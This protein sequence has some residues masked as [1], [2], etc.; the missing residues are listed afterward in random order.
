MIP[1]NPP[2]PENPPRETVVAR[3]RANAAA[4]PEAPALVCGDTRLTWGAFD[5]RINRVANAL[6]GMGIRKGDNV[7]ILSANSIPYAELFMGILRAGGC[8]TPLSSMAA[9][10]A[11]H[12]M[13]ADC[14]ARAIFVAEQYFG[15]VEGFVDDLDLHRVAIDFDREGMADYETLLAE[16]DT[17]DPMVPLEMSDAF[18]LIYSSGT[19]GTP[20]GILHNHWMRAAQMDRVSPNGYDDNARTLISTPLYSN[21]TIVAFIPTLFG[22]STVHLMPKFD[23]RAYLE[24]VEREGIT[25]TMLVPVQYK[26]IMDVPDFDSFDLSSMRVKFSTSAPLRADVK[27]DVLDRFPGKLIEYYGL[28]EGGGVSVLVADENPTKLHTVGQPAPGNDIRLID[29]EGREVP[30]GEVGEIVGRGPTMMA[31]YFGRDDLTADYIWRDENDRVYFRSGDMG[32][33]DEDG[34]LVLSDRKKDM[35]ISGGLNIYANDLELILLDDADVVDAAVIGVP[36]DAWGET[37]LGLVVLRDGATRTG[38]E[39]LEKANARLGKSHR[40]SAVEL[41]ETLPRSTI[42]KILK[43]DLRAPY[44]EKEKT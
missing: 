38:D 1:T 43:R 36:S 39:I 30:Q 7:A 34:F 25:H 20:K 3:I 31:G 28:T 2:T 16:A 37:P 22:G 11:L 26:R 33:F 19:T 8:V 40:L 13:L 23:A 21:T 17:T 18:N 12:K 29:T 9:P 35:I 10:E 44:W 32:S 42:G 4:H 14:G 15:L 27:K 6:I 24:I 5:A 41:R